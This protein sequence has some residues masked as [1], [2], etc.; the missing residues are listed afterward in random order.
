VAVRESV[1]RVA[2][3]GLGAVTA[4]G[5]DV[6][7]LLAG[8]ESGR[9][10]I[11]PLTRFTHG[12]R[13][14][15][16]AQVPE[17]VPPAAV[18][19]ALPPATVRRLSRP[20]R[21]ALAAADQ[22]L[23]Q[24]GLDGAG[25]TAA[26]VFV[27]ATVG[28]MAGSEEEYRRCRPDGGGR[29]RLSRLLASPLSTTAAAVAQTFGLRGP[30]ATFSTACSASALAVADA[31]AA[32]ASGRLAAALVVGT[33]ALCRT[34]Y[35]GFDALQALD[36]EGCRPF[37]R[38]RAG[39]SLGEGAGALLLEDAAHASARGA[40][41]LAHVLGYGSTLDAHHVTA[42]HPGGDR[43]LAAVHAAL[44]VA[45]LPPHAVDYVN[46]HGTGTRH[47]DDAEVAVLRAAFGPHLGRLPV[48]STKAQLGHCLGA[49]GAI[50]AVTTVLAIG[51]SLLPAT[52]TL[53]VPD[54]AWADLDLV[55]TPGRRHAIAVALS[56][57]YGFGGHNVA[58]LFGRAT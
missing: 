7:A 36:P 52:V 27:G 43:A 16:A 3:T 2:V 38:D 4:L 11:G 1:C 31:A 20:D 14:R 25:R 58:L 8:L 55:P 39:L 28:G 54:P 40:R 48:S 44:A 33:D 21:I 17:I 47:N 19:R 15:V 9:P 50:E 10:G 35:A 26:A 18:T 6:G 45:G 49:A 46:A 56:S 41:P 34:T 29:Y 53:R 32:I 5:G 24:A 51:R 23:R 30:R 57:S 12:G 37:D 22:A 42:P 13:C